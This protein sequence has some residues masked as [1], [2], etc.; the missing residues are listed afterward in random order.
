MAEEAGLTV[1]V[2]DAEAVAE[3]TGL[4]VAVADAEVVLEAD[5]VHARPLTVPVTEDVAVAEEELVGCPEG[6]GRG[7]G[8]PGSAHCRGVT[9]TPRCM[10]VPA[11]F[12]YTC[13][14]CTITARSMGFVER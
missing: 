9:D 8:V 11:L 12:T 3:E 10:C 13:V 4:T 14:H 6:L 2:A 1:A 5:C 7:E